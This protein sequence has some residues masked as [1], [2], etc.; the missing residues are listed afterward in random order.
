MQPSPYRKPNMAD[1]DGESLRVPEESLPG[2]DTEGARD[3]AAFDH[4]L[5]DPRGLP[6]RIRIRR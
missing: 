1:R 3:A 4:C 6:V 5:E 2:V